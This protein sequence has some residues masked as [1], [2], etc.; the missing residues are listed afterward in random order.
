MRA[1]CTSPLPKLIRIIEV[2]P[3]KI[4]LLWSTSE[5]RTLDFAPL[6]KRWATEDDTRMAAL[7]HWGTF[8]QVA[9]SENRTLHWPNV[10]VS[11]H[12]KGETR[13]A[14]LK[15]DALELYR[16]S[17][18][19]R[20]T[21]TVQVGA[22]LREAREAAGLSQADVAL[23]SGTI[24]DYISRVENDKSAIQLETLHKI[25]ELGSVEK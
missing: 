23:K 20:K 3:F 15:L 8:Q 4:T 16:Q 25:I 13:S 14:P 12:F 10:P 5:I 22:I 7:Q 9:L 21:G 2:Q 17:V 18:L 1:G 19:V 6:F 11:F 24:R